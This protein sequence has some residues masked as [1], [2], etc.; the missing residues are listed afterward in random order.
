GGKYAVGD[1]PDMQQVAETAAN[2]VLIAM[3][4]CGRDRSQ[5]GADRDGRRH[6]LPGRPRAAGADR[7]GGARG[8]P[9]H[10]SAPGLRIIRLM[11]PTWVLGFLEG[12]R[13]TGNVAA[14]CR[15]AGCSTS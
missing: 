10:L 15:A 6:A 1:P 14:S 9:V 2:Q 4:G 11:R 7:A 3:A 12:L 5:P 8:R 13:A